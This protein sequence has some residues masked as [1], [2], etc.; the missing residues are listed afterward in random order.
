MDSLYKA[1]IIDHYK[2]PRN[3]GNLENADYVFLSRN[4]SCG[5][6]IEVFLK[7]EEEK[8]NKIKFTARGCAISIAAMSIL[9]EKL[10][11]LEIADIKAISEIE[12]LQ[13]VGLSEGSARRGCALLGLNAVKEALSI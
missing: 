3:Q 5:D 1:K 9:S 7:V 11:G 13:S 10:K 6:E 8:I 2:N 4:L 12:I